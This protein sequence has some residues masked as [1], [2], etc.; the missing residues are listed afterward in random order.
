MGGPLGI[1]E[2]GERGDYDVKRIRRIAS[3]SRGVRQQGDHPQHLD[4]R[5]GPSMCQD[6]RNR[7]GAFTAFMDEVDSEAV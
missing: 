3:M 7:G 4:K 2:S 5:S 6:Q 1:A